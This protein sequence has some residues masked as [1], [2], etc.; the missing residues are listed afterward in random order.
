VQDDFLESLKLIGSKPGLERLNSKLGLERIRFLL[1]KSGI[2]WEDIPTVHI[3]GTNG[4]GSVVTFISEILSQ[5]NYKVGSYISPHLIDIYERIKIGD[6]NIPPKDFDRILY[7]LKSHCEEAE[8][9]GDIGSPTFFEVLTA[10]SIIYFTEKKVDFIVS[11]VGLGG[12]LDATNILNGKAVAITNIS[13][14]HQEILGNSREE[15]LAEKAG[16]IKKGSIVSSCVDLEL[17]PLLEKICNEK[18]ASLK[19]L[20]RDFEVME[21]IIS[22]DGSVFD[23]LSKDNLFNDVEIR[24]IGRHQINNAACAI[25]IAE[26]LEFLGFEIKEDSIRKGLEKSIW[27]GRFQIL[28]RNPMILVDV[29]HNEAGAKSLSDTYNSL[30]TDSKTLLLVGISQDK[31]IDGIFEEFSKISKRIVLTT[32]P[33]RCANIDI[34]EEKARKYFKEIKSFEDPLKAF[35]YCVS[36]L[37]KEDKLLITG[38]IYVAGY[39]LKGRKL[40]GS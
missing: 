9:I 8:K 16:I 13:L 3:A 18:E 4:K 31:D 35:D 38:S 12:R 17:A 2:N 10:V 27:P 40:L 7:E 5:S 26:S 29:A 36:N 33:P 34:L 24:M 19:L 15:I 32:I 28:R 30:F 39:I 37:K 20:N 14:D 21:K 23:Y 6:I 11:E 1:K 25:S 22:F